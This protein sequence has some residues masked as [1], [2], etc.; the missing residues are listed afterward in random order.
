MNVYKLLSVFFLVLFLS[1]HI[2][3]EGFFDSAN[4]FNYYVNNTVPEIEVHIKKPTDTLIVRG[5]NLRYNDKNN[6]LNLYQRILVGTS[7]IVEIKLSDFSGQGPIELNDSVYF[8]LDVVKDGTETKIQTLGDPVKFNI[9]LD[10]E[11]PELINLSSSTQLV[12]KLDEEFSFVFNEKISKFEITDMGGKL[13]LRR[14][15]ELKS[16]EEE[17][18]NII[19]FKFGVGQLIEGDNK[20]IVSFSDL[21]GNKVKKEINFGFRGDELNIKLLTR[22]NDSSLKY[23]YDT[24]NSD[25]F[26]NKIQFMENEYDLVI[27]TNKKATCYFSSS[28]KKVIKY[29]NISTNA[30]YS[31]FSSSDSLKK[32]TYSMNGETVVWIACQDLEFPSEVVYL[33]QMLGLGDNLIIFEKYNL[34]FE[35]SEFYPYSVISS[36]LFDVE[37]HTTQDTICSY[38]INNMGIREFSYNSSNDYKKHTQRDI[39]EIDGSHNIKVECYDK[40]YNVKNEVKNILIDRT[41]GARVIGDKEFYSDSKTTSISLQFSE[42]VDCVSSKN[43]IIYSEI[44]SSTLVNGIGLEKTITPNDLDVGENDYY[45][46]CGDEMIESKIEILFDPAQP[47]IKDLVFVNNEGSSEY[48][49]DDKK[50]SYKVTY[51]GLIPVER[52]E[53]KI[54]YS[55]FTIKKNFSKSSGVYS[56]DISNVKKFKIKLVNKLDK[57]S[58]ELEK[59]IKFDLEGPIVSIRK[60]GNNKKIS[61]VDD[62]SGCN[63]VYYGFSQT[64]INC[65][66]NTEYVLGDEIEVGNNLY[67]CAR[68]IDF[69]GNENIDQVSLFDGSFKFEGNQGGTGKNNVSVDNPNIVEDPGDSN[70]NKPGDTNTVNDNP[71]TRTSGDESTTSDSN[72]LIIAAAIIV[73]L[74]GIG[75][76]G[77]Y[78]YREGYLDKQLEKY[79]IFRNSSSSGALSPSTGATS[80]S[81]YTPI[82]KTNEKKSEPVK[83]TGYDRNLKKINSFIDETLSKGNDVFDSFS[84]TSK[85]KTK[86]YDDTLLKG[87]SSKNKSQ[88]FSLNENNGVSKVDGESI[89]KQAEEFENYFKQK[90]SESKDK[91]EK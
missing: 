26:G 63:K 85:G 5:A 84:S 89:E 60:S 52:Y 51:E 11:N 62:E 59:N 33:N 3:S 66:A 19:T 58:N 91:K 6:Y 57:T 76:G 24:E 40:V 67:I 69:V 9:I 68:A 83:K 53:V 86:G 47:T 8:E 54:E 72:G 64:A 28:F 48:L 13:I 49:V 71:F 15:T 20:Y 39:N 2:Y 46:Y 80:S 18:S 10:N 75:G 82:S 4:N 12:S 25:F 1:S 61:C 44:K 41:S 23:F 22:K 7:D 77:Y 74:G 79:G 43:Q 90:G 32:H 65:N 81:V 55:N 27:E 34:D 42:D 78:A 16:Y 38:K 87:T 17:Y 56:G 73:L 36:S 29:E 50:I 70:I 88:E 35:I 45:I 14:P 31:E 30:A 21:A 37:V